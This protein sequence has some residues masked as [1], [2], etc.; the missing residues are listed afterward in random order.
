[1]CVP[2]SCRLSRVVTFLSRGKKRKKSGVSQWLST[3]AATAPRM[4]N[5]TPTVNHPPAPQI[6]SA[7]KVSEFAE[8]FFLVCAWSTGCV[9]AID[10]TAK[11]LS[12]GLRVV[13]SIPFI[14]RRKRRRNKKVHNA[15]TYQPYQLPRATSMCPIKPGAPMPTKPG[16]YWRDTAQWVEYA[17]HH[18]AL[19][20]DGYNALYQA[21]Y[22]KSKGTTKSPRSSSSTVSSAAQDNN[23]GVSALRFFGFLDQRPSSPGTP[24]SRGLGGGVVAGDLTPVTLRDREWIVALG[25]IVSKEHPRG[26]QYTV[27]LRRGVQVSARGFAREVMIVGKTDAAGPSRGVSK[28]LKFQCMSSEVGHSGEERDDGTTDTPGMVEGREYSSG[29]KKHTGVA[30]S[31]LPL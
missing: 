31:L 10:V 29:G 5:G 19:I 24:P 16:V 23:D 27:D 20:I 18:S 13:T 4:V 2:P 26:A 9:F 14:G 15:E 30:V 25:L 21:E 11:V 3:R 8:S 22:E 17:P 7:A 6:G 12:L 1:M 28:L